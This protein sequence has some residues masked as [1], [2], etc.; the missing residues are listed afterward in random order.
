MHG[1]H[2]HGMHMHMHVQHPHPHA[3]VCLGPHDNELRAVGPQGG[4]QLEQ[5]E[6]AEVVVGM[7]VPGG[8]KEGM[9]V[10]RVRR[11]R[12]MGGAGR[13]GRAAAAAVARGGMGVW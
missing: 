8:S 2:M 5:V 7:H 6:Q 11:A 1:T 4:T 3:E 13:A 10:R 9:L 12:R